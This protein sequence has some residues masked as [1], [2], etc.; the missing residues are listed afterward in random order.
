MQKVINV[1]Q[2]TKSFKNQ[3]VL[4]GLSFSVKAGSVV[5][6]LGNNG[7]GKTTLLQTMLGYL[8]ADSGECLIFNEPSPDFSANTKHKI[9]YVPQEAELI[10]WM[11]VEQLI[12]YTKSFYQRW[13]QELVNNLLIEWQLVGSQMVDKLSVGQKQKLAIILA[14]AHEPELLILDEPVASLDPVS[15][16]NF[17]K[18]LID[19]NLNKERTIIFSTHIT[20]DLERVAA[21]VLI[22][23]D[24]M[25]YFHGDIDELKEKV[26]RLHLLAKEPL[27]ATLPI[28]G[29]LHSRVN[30]RNAV[31]T[32]ENFHLINME[33]LSQQ[34]NA[35][36]TVESLSL[37]DIYVEL[38]S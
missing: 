30:G 18:K 12:S 28:P 22:V 9:G 29:L 21:E 11:T 36:I 5:G 16:R 1:N 34:L 23:K 17:I 33:S 19:M 10:S 20:S 27:P 4:N 6:I 8:R 32:I 26:V 25:N 24:G 35:R 31:V 3:T 13:D 7:A 2:L 14:V 38:H 37:E 15:R